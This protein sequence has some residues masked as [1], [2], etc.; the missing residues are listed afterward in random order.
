MRLPDPLERPVMAIEEAGRH[1]QMGRSAAY[2][3][4]ARGDLPT[5]SFGRRKVVPTARLRQLLGIDD[6]SRDEGTVPTQDGAQV[7]PMMT[8]KMRPR[9]SP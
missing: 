1:L 9:G 7:I 8:P 4:A 5:I 6:P 3:A 2:A